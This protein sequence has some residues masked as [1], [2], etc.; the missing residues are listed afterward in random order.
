[1]GGWGKD[2]FKKAFHANFSQHIS[3]VL[4]CIVMSVFK[5]AFHA[6]FSQHI[7]I[8]LYCIVMSVFQIIIKT[9]KS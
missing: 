9:L 6:N 1:M 8:V 2:F 3:I 4:Y 5:K 7:S